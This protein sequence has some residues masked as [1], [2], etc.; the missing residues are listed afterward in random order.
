MT[1]PDPNRAMTTEE[2]LDALR[3]QGLAVHRD[4][5]IRWCK[6]GMPHVAGPAK[7]GWRR[8]FLSEVL[9]WLRQNKQETE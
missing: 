6:A 7:G 9:E 1:T 8:Y 2:L 4:T 5:L 3:A